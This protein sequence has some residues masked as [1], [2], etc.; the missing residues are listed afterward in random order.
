MP[1]RISVADLAGS[2]PPAPVPDGITPAEEA[3]AKWLH[4]NLRGYWGWADALDDARD[5]LAALDGPESTWRGIFVAS[6]KAGWT[7]RGSS[8]WAMWGIWRAE[9]IDDSHGWVVSH[10]INRVRRVTVVG[11]GSGPIQARQSA[12]LIDPT[13]AKIMAALGLVGIGGGNA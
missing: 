11:P 1:D 4:D 7:R 9:D 6:R 13:P 10:K 12:E 2:C 3:A 8:T 5:L